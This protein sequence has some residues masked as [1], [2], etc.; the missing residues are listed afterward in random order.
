MKQ[1]ADKEFVAMRRIIETLQGFD[2]ASRN[3]I[4]SYVTARV[5]YM[6]EPELSTGVPLIVEVNPNAGTP[7]ANQV[8]LP[9][10]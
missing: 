3:R 6:G 10:K 7:L 9:L 1:Q 4:M 2:G 5:P 8:A